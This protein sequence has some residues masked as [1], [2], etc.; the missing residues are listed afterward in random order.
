MSQNN[1]KVI[2]LIIFIAFVLTS[3]KSS[4]DAQMI[5][6][7]PS[8]SAPGTMVP[9][10]P[11]FTPAYLKGIVIHP[12]NALKFDFIVYKGDKPLSQAE[13]KQEYT[14]LTKY[15]LAS[16][17]I[18][19]EDQ[20]VN[21][22]PYEKDRIIKNDFGKTE[23]G[24]D[25]LAQDYMLK[26]I[27]ASLIYPE[28]NLGKKFWDRVYSQAQAKFGTSNIPVNTFNKVW[29]LPD[30]ALI[31]EKGNTAYVVKNHLRVM[32][33]EDYLSLKNHSGIQSAPVS[34]A[35]TIASKIVRE[36]VLPELQREVNEDQ[37][38][39]TVRQVYSS[40]LLATWYKRALKESLLTKIYANRAKVKG[41]DA[42][43][44]SNEKI[45]RQYLKAYK[46]GVFNFIKEDVDKYTNETIPRKY[47]S[48]GMEDYAQAAAVL[49]K[50][51]PYGITHS[52]DAAEIANISDNFDY[53]SVAAEESAETGYSIDKERRRHD[54]MIVGTDAAMIRQESDHVWSGIPSGKAI[55]IFNQ[56]RNRFTEFSF[57]KL[58]SPFIEV[59][60]MQEGNRRYEVIDGVTKI[61]GPGIEFKVKSDKDTFTIE[62]DPGSPKEIYIDSD[63]AAKYLQGYR[64]F[65]PGGLGQGMMLRP[66]EI[67]ADMNRMYGRG[68]PTADQRNIFNEPRRT[69]FEPSVTQDEIQLSLS[70]EK[71]RQEGK[72]WFYTA[73]PAEVLMIARIARIGRSDLLGMPDREWYRILL[74]NEQRKLNLLKNAIEETPNGLS[75]ETS[76]ALEDSLRGLYA[77]DDLGNL[78]LPQI[79]E[80]GRKAGPRVAVIIKDLVEH[81]REYLDAIEHGTYV[82][83]IQH[84][85]VTMS[86][87]DEAMRVQDYLNEIANPKFAERL[88]EMRNL[89]RLNR[90]RLTTY[91]DFEGQ[92]LRNIAEYIQE[93]FFHEIDFTTALYIAQAIAR[94]RQEIVR[95]GVSTPG[96]GEYFCE[97]A[98]NM[99]WSSPEV[100]PLNV[101]FFLDQK[102]PNIIFDPM[103]GRQNV[104]IFLKNEI[105]SVM[106]L[107]FIPTIGEWQ[108]MT[109]DGQAYHLPEVGSRINSTYGFSVTVLKGNQLQI[110]S[111]DHKDEII[112][113]KGEEIDFNRE[114]VGILKNARRQAMALVNV[115]FG[116]EQ[117]TRERIDK[118]FDHI[119]AAIDERQ[120]DLARQSYGQIINNETI[121]SIQDFEL[122]TW[123]DMLINAQFKQLFYYL[124]FYLGFDFN[125]AMAS[126]A[127]IPKEFSRKVHSQ[128]AYK[129]L[130]E[131]KDLGGI[132]FNS[133]NLNLQIKRDGKG[134]P[135]PINQQNLANIHLEGLIPVVEKIFPASKTQL[136]SQL[137]LN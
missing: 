119:G 85:P 123:H 65:L 113:V 19:D 3:V 73:S 80:A 130:Q 20:W 132:D 66:F 82:N 39:A 16:L 118:L 64:E 29:I 67:K 63:D 121:T 86:P 6:P 12:E 127:L 117:K 99:D 34:S 38:F 30:D 137:Q 114:L 112:R 75:L 135:L 111:L 129:S 54:R 50:N 78:S 116:D 47:F 57:R 37:N 59:I 51:A 91:N 72:I 81:S 125:A 104:A 41:V 136:L 133:A 128:H 61:H 11:E 25:L 131:A 9:L 42:D 58:K 102:N 77:N 97:I 52:L 70:K 87:V 43:P 18:P 98:V 44:R 71:M 10:S 95:A 76:Y 122:A 101:T 107:R 103:N 17:A 35:H 89:F 90:E 1:K 15:F 32:L 110:S 105:V 28:S 49:H 8:L 84:H 53:A 26:Q 134:V 69:V 21:L 106:N 7:M 56:P 23:M 83:I 94:F 14:K 45:Y 88:Q 5:D 36:I 33:E 4:A 27:T 74:A 62:I 2:S 79:R 24:R 124:G 40:M 22:S 92:T 31:Y 46:K 68:E 93:H 126:N 120:Y 60:D 55:T 96:G 48:G 13:K 115:V 100:K 109:N 108:F